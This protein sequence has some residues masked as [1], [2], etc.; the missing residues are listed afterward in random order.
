[1]TIAV[2]GATG[3]LGRLAVDALLR[4][5]VPASDVVAVV[6]NP[7]KAADLAAQGVQ[8]RTA[9]YA[10]RAALETALAGV[11]KL[12]LISG[13]EVGARVPQHTNIID[14]AKA[15]GVGFVAYTS[16]PDAPNNTLRLAQEHQVTERLLAE[17]GID[18]ALLRNGWYWENYTNDLAGTAERGVLVGSAGDGRVAGAARAD[19]A[20]AAAAALTSDENQAG[21]VYELGGDEHVSYPELAQAISNVTG[22]PSSTGTCRS[23]ST[24]ASSSP[25]ACPRPSPQSSPTPTP[26]SRPA[27]ST[28]PAATCSGSSGGRPPARGRAAGRALT[29]PVAAE[30]SVHAP[31][32][33]ERTLQLP[34]GE[35]GRNGQCIPTAPSVGRS[36]F[37]A[38]TRTITSG[39]MTRMSAPA[40]PNA[41]A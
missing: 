1:M 37:L 27:S 14:A 16:I 15:A 31:A 33:H 5:G 26:V 34:E 32:A 8:V 41:C 39:L 36:P 38:R 30:G 11:D 12:L 28:S 17:S 40:Q 21:K 7:E 20:E 18:H 23:R 35:G 9:D 6:R 10:D 29:A 24:R 2:T 3:H 25:S 4:R 13:S 22:K 19:Y